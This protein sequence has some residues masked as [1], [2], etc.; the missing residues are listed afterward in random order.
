MIVFL[1]SCRDLSNPPDQT[2]L[3]GCLHRAAFKRAFAP[4]Y[5][6]VVRDPAQIAWLRRLAD[7]DQVA[8]TK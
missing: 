3:R 7:A 8:P 6:L 1:L 4:L 2:S 5:P